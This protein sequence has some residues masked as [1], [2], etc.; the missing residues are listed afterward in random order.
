MAKDGAE[1]RGE[2]TTR[3]NL[4]VGAD[5]PDIL[6][7]LAGSARKRG[8]YITQLVRAIHSGQQDILIDVT[9]KQPRLNLASIISKQEE[10]EGRVRK[11]EE[12]LAETRPKHG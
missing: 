6:S 12:Q 1:M 9:P 5:V 4:V 2:E 8:D 10:L 3:I 11:L 7:E